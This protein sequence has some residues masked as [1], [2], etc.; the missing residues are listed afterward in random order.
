[1]CDFPKF[2]LSNAF[3]DL[4]GWLGF[5]YLFWL[6]GATMFL[7]F[8]QK[9]YRGLQ[10][11][12]PYFPTTFFRLLIEF[13][14]LNATA[15]AAWISYSCKNWNN[16]DG[17][18]VHI[19]YVI[20]LFSFAIQIAVFM[21]PSTLWLV[22][23]VTA[24]SAVLSLVN[25]ILCVVFVNNIWSLLIFIAT[26][27]YLAYMALNFIMVAVYPKKTFK[28]IE[29]F[30]KAWDEGVKNCTERC[31]FA[32]AE[33]NEELANEACALPPREKKSVTPITNN[34]FETERVNDDSRIHMGSRVGFRLFQ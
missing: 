21:G 16:D 8:Y 3:N 9:Y 25:V 7:C 11:E 10:A 1:M 26:T 15:M 22:A 32:A 5:N 29:K 30:A 19:M 13:V 28:G 34:D 27:I 18:I 14:L 23:A 17:L 31:M 2:T 6:G 12:R 4:A 24:L 20:W 33:E